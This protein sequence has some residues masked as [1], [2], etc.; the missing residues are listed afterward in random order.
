MGLTNSQ[1]FAAGSS[2]GSST[3]VYEKP[4]GQVNISGSNN[5]VA[6]TVPAGK[7]FVGR[8]NQYNDYNYP[9]KINN[10]T[11]TARF[12]NN[13]QSNDGYDHYG[14]PFTLYAGTVVKS[15]TYGPVR[16]VGVEYDL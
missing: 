4:T 12:H 16:I 9:P 5:T 10:V 8:L 13:D 15:G 11:C 7:Y 2:G 1:S 14:Y 6:Y 3:V